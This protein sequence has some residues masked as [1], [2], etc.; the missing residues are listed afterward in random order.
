MVA[1]YDA[2]CGAVSAYVDISQ[3]HMARR[4]VRDGRQSLGQFRFG[5]HGI[6]HKETCALERVRTRQSNERVDIAGVG[7]VGAIERAARSHE[8]VR[9]HTFIEP[10]QALKIEVHRV[11]IRSLF[12]AARLG[13]GEL[14]VQRVGQTPQQFRPACRRDRRAAYR[15]ARPKDDCRIRVDELHVDARASSAVLD[16]T[17]ED[18]TDVQLAADLFQIDGFALVSEGGVSTD[19]DG[20]AYA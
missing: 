2:L 18:R 19:H 15:T 10:S 14:G 7:G 20:A 4:M 12:R 17:L 11:G 8:I 13:G 9:G 3:K 6:A 1:F 16:A 5:R